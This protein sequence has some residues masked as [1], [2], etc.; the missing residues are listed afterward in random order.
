ML[1]NR[2]QNY[3]GLVWIDITDILADVCFIL[4][5]AVQC[6]TAKLDLGD[7]DKSAACT[8]VRTGKGDKQAW[9]CQSTRR[10]FMY[11]F[12]LEWLPSTLF[13]VVSSSGISLF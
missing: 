5:G 13:R 6:N 11:T 10:Y 12:T 9:A 3:V 7:D 2:L 1:A 8:A 4:D